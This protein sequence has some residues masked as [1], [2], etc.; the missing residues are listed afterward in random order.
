MAQL[1]AV[2]P[3]EEARGR[4]AAI[5]GVRFSEGVVLGIDG[6]EPLGP[7]AAGAL[8]ILHMTA[9]DP[10]LTENFWNRT[11]ALKTLLPTREGFI[12]LIGFFDGLS[13]YALVFWRTV[14]DAQAFA[15]SSEHAAAADELFETHF[16]YTHFIGV[17][18]AERIHPRTFHCDACG[19]LTHAPAETCTACGTSLHDVF[20]EQHAAVPTPTT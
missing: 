9:V 12:R 19:Q 16:E 14:E 2:P 8:Q 7:E 15:G 1:R 18:R 3:G 11:S 4:I 10:E 6:A 20:V 13:A 5:P 17:W